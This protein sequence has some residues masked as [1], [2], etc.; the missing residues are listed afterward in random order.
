MKKEILKLNLQIPKGK[1]IEYLEKKE[2]FRPYKLFKKMVKETLDEEFLAYQVSLVTVT[3]ISE[4]ENKI[5]EENN[6]NRYS[7]LSFW[8]SYEDIFTGKPLYKHKFNYSVKNNELTLV[9]DYNKNFT[10]NN[11]FNYK[12]TESLKELKEALEDE[13]IK[14]KVM[15]KVTNIITSKIDFAFEYLMDKVTNGDNS[16]LEEEIF[17]I[18]CDQKANEYYTKYLERRK[19]NDNKKE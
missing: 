2:E 3:G 8:L 9:L 13:S 11:H 7:L 10:G 14:D 19:L 16:H 15:K 17:L 5:Y 1:I 18:I 6:Q 12:L 4:I